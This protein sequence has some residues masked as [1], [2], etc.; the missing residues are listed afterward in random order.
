ML[1]TACLMLLQTGTGCSRT[2]EAAPACA[3]RQQQRHQPQPCEHCLSPHQSLGQWRLEAV[4]LLRPL[5]VPEHLVESLRLAALTL[6]SMLGL[7]LWP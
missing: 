4:A 1:R 3:W 2:G 6:S 7:Q 5:Q